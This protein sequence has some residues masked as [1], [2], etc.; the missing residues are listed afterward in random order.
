MYDNK[1]WVALCSYSELECCQLALVQNKPAINRMLH[2][3]IHGPGLNIFTKMLIANCLFR[4]THSYK[5]HSHLTEPGVIQ[6]ML[7]FYDSC[8]GG[9]GYKPILAMR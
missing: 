3:A 5:T 6:Q 8:Q 1:M 4:L 9:P 7:D 2:F